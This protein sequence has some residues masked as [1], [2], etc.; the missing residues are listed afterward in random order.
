MS[1]GVV[2]F[3]EGEGCWVVMM[4]II[5][6]IIIIITMIMM[7]MMLLLVL[8]LLQMCAD[9]PWSVPT[10][11]HDVFEFYLLGCENRSRQLV[12]HGR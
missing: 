3:F 1:E 7:I 6:M 9:L 11:V 8:L 12:V 4:M 10:Q 2:V 5:I